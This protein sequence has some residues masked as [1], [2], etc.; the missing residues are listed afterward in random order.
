M[1]LK[2]IIVE[3]VTQKCCQIVH[4]CIFIAISNFIADWLA[5]TKQTCSQG[6][7]HALAWLSKKYLIGTEKLYLFLTSKKELKKTLSEKN[8]SS[9]VGIYQSVNLMPFKTEKF[10]KRLESINCNPI[11]LK[12]VSNCASR[13]RK[14]L[15]GS[16]LPNNT[17]NLHG[18]F[19]D[20]TTHLQVT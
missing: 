13:L 10:S 19:P 6:M 9:K 15:L 5:F 11:R 4:V 7:T 8:C 14:P 3:T 2:S 20:R 18:S 12:K 17:V 16:E 1:K